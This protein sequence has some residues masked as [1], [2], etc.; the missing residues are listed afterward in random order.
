[1]IRYVLAVLLAVSLLALG[2]LALA[3]SSTAATEREV[4]TA[5]S[6]IEAAA[7]DLAANEEVSPAG[8][9]DP[10]RVVEVSI[11]ERSLLTTGVSHVEIEPVEEDVDASMARYVLDDGTT[12]QEVLDVRLVAR[13]QTGSRTTLDGAGTHRL[14]LRLVSDEQ[15]DPLVVTERV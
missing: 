4:R 11:P 6:D 7:I 3:E 2:G 14:R 9:P 13:N 5:M 1:M 10:Q 15:G 8:H 12:N